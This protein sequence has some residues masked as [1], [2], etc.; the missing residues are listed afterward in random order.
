M[1]CFSMIYAR[2]DPIIRSDLRMQKT[3]KR[4]FIESCKLGWNVWGMPV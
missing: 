2:L 4:I 1:N 3:T